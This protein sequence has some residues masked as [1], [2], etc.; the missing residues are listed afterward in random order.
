[1]RWWWS[2]EEKKSELRELASPGA[3]IPDTIERSHRRQNPLVLVGWWREYVYTFYYSRYDFSSVGTVELVHEPEW[4]DCATGCFIGV[5]LCALRMNFGFDFGLQWEKE[6]ANNN[7]SFITSL[8]EDL[9][10]RSLPFAIVEAEHRKIQQP[11]DVYFPQILKF[12]QFPFIN[13]TGI[14]ATGLFGGALFGKNASPD[15]NCVRLCLKS[16]NLALAF[17][18]DAVKKL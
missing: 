6:T 18:H 15:G 3:R 14:F 7:N 17:S 1:M 10:P 5:A 16:Y 11:A 12:I 4:H 8:G 2:F 13:R 9:R